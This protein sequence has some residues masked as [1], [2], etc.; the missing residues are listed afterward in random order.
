MQPIPKTMTKS[1]NQLIQKWLNERQSLIVAFNHLCSL[2]PFTAEISEPLQE[3][4]QLLVDYVSLGHFEVYEYIVNAVEQC[5]QPKVQIP[6]RLLLA[7]M[8]TTVSALD[9][10]DKY[11]VERKT[12]QLDAD[13]SKLGLR[14]AQRLEWEDSLL[15]AYRLAKSWGFQ[16]AKTA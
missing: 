2:R 1:N 13:L 8:D 14:F 15:E 7:L 10:N 9:F 16:Q 12:D 11:Q 5:P 6:K 3:F 4:C